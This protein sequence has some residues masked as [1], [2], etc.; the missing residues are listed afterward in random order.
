[1]PTLIRLLVIL[2]VCGGGSV[3]ISL[4]LS[5]IGSR[6]SAPGRQERACGDTSPKKVIAA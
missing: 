2:F 5:A 3:A 6:L 4:G 1:V